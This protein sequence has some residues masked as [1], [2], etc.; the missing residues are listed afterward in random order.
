MA[1]TFTIKSD[2]SVEVRVRLAKKVDG[3]THD[4]GVDGSA[5]VGL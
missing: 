1:T 2:G 5:C 3:V 4:W